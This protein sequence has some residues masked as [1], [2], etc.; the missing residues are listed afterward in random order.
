MLVVGKQAG[1]QA[2]PG[3]TVCVSTMASSCPHFPP[4]KWR[5]E[6]V[7]GWGETVEEA[8]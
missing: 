5:G 1:E 7:C 8:S 4:A 6:G 2:G 3:V